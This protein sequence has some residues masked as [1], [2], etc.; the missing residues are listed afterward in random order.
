MQNVTAIVYTSD[1]SLGE[2]KKSNALCEVLFRPAAEWV[3]LAL[4]AAGIDHRLYVVHEGEEEVLSYANGYDTV[5]SSGDGMNYAS[6]A[7]YVE[8]HPDD[9][10][11]LICAEAIF[12]SGS[13]IAASLE[14]HR[15]IGNRMTVLA[16]GGRAAFISE[17]GVSSYWIKGTFLSELFKNEEVS[18]ETSEKFIQCALKV[19]SD[20]GEV[21]STYIA[22]RKELNMR[23]SYGEGGVTINAAA[24]TVVM[25]RLISAGVKM[26]CTDGVIITPDAVIG[27]GTMILPGTIIKGKTVIGENCVIGPNSY[28]E[29]SRIG[30][31]TEVNSTQIR[32]SVLEENV[33]IGPFSQVRP[34]CIIHDGCKIG[35]FVE[36]KNSEVGAR[37]AVAHLTYIGD[38]TVGEACNFG[39]GCCVANYDGQNKHRTVI[40][41]HV[42]LGCNTNLVAPVTLGDF[43]YTAAG[44]TISKDVP[45]Y[46]LAVARERQSNIEGWVKA[47]DAIKIK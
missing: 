20:G 45:E 35:D 17:L 2:D 29:D 28:I 27:K 23:A 40:G 36:I 38:S 33:K 16:S 22:S 7:E 14:R 44:S 32:S 26:L 39:C 31:G 19:L 34:G 47:H 15:E 30:N 5:I 46:A 1:A 21:A 24:R 10:F 25:K 12:T 8:N 3:N 9:D 18:K 11:F 13:D 41:D 43:S 42:F 37:T 6:A 4:D